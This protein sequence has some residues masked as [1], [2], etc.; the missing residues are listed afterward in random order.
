MEKFFIIFIL[1]ISIF[2]SWL[3]SANEYSIES[4]KREGF[5][6]SDVNTTDKLPKSLQKIL[7]V[8]RKANAFSVSKRS[9]EADFVKNK[10]HVSFAKHHRNYNIVKY[11]MENP[12]RTF[13]GIFDKPLNLSD[14]GNGSYVLKFNEEKNELGWVAIMAKRLW[15]PPSSEGFDNKRYPY[16]LIS[17][18]EYARRIN[19][20][21]SD[22]GLNRV[23]TP[24]SHIVIMNNDVEPNDD[25]S[26]YVA[27]RV[28]WNSELNYTNT[29]NDAIE[30]NQDAI[31]LIS[32]TMQVIY[33]AGFW[34]VNDDNIR[35]LS[36]Y[37]ATFTDTECPGIGGNP[38]L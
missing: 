35:F 37:E 19:N 8:V 28:T 25:N 17:R 15:Y 10:N 6:I 31:T 32:E 9:P 13:G 2:F 34:D 5:V 38:W 14:C 12:D 16:Q 22:R 29:C 30:G 36:G 21:I 11:L 7:G 27:E 23:K 18:M 4:W 26:Y 24:K 1:S 3:L 20:I 33:H